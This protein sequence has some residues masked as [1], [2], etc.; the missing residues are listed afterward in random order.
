[1]HCMFQIKTKY[2]LLLDKVGIQGWKGSTMS[3]LF[4][5][6]HLSVRLQTDT[7]S[8]W[9]RG[10]MVHSCSQRKRAVKP[11][12][13][14]FWAQKSYSYRNKHQPYSRPNLFDCTHKLPDT[15]G[16]CQKLSFPYSKENWDGWLKRY[17]LQS[18]TTYKIKY[19]QVKITTKKWHGGFWSG[20]ERQ[21][22]TLSTI[23]LFSWGDASLQWR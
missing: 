12:R 23:H 1:M 13:L 7:S 11:P 20:K 4:W 16:L 22:H 3:L 5:A 15:T 21:R 9:H 18:N 6:R 14:L 8:L 17:S 2:K 19:V 10:H